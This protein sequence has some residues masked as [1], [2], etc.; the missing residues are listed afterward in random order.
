MNIIRQTLKINMQN[1]SQSKTILVWAGFFVYPIM[2]VIYCCQSCVESKSGACLFNT[3]NPAAKTFQFT[4]TIELSIVKLQ[5]N[6][7]RLKRL[8]AWATSN[9]N[10][11]LMLGFFLNKTRFIQN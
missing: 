1:G 11:K 3:A 7:V 4:S 2:L 9:V 8:L 6:Q 5:S 10:E